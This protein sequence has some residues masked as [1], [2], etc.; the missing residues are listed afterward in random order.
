M[1]QLSKQEVTISHAQIRVEKAGKKTRKPAATLT[2]VAVGGNE[3]LDLF[4]S[5]LGKTFFRKARKGAEPEKGDIGEQQDLVAGAEGLV[6]LKHPAIAALPIVFEKEGYEFEIEPAN[7]GDKPIFFADVKV[8]ECEA[9][10]FEGGTVHVKSKLSFPTE[11]A[12]AVDI[13]RA[14]VREKVNF[15]LTPPSKQEGGQ[16]VDGA[17]SGVDPETDPTKPNP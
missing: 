9:E 11:F 2:I 6:K 12:D 7:E 3:L 13:H 1:Y 15:T 14:W 5:G 17:D 16:T 4:E 10:L 8:S